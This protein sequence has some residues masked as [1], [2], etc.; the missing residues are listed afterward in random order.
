MKTALT[1]KVNE[2]EKRLTANNTFAIGGGS[3]SADSFVVAESSVL[4]INFC[5]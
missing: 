1:Q 5:G 2:R 4:R 3:Y